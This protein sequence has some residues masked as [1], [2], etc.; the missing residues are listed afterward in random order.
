MVQTGDALS[1]Q[2]EIVVPDDSYF[3]LGDNRNNSSDSREYGT[4]DEIKFK[5]LKKLF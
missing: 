1:N 5:V 2:K 3:L 4:F